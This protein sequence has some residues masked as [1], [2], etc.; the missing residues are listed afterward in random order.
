MVAT[1]SE[2][3]CQGQNIPFF[4]FSPKLDEIITAG[5][6]DNDKLF[7]MI[8]KTKT[9]MRN[10]QLSELKQ[11][12]H[13]IA[14]QQQ[15]IKADLSRSQS[16]VLPY[17][18]PVLPKRPLAKHSSVPPSHE[19]SKQVHTTNKPADKQVNGDTH[20]SSPTMCNGGHVAGK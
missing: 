5:E 15:R 6:T 11:L 10:G 8:L 12:F 1:N 9:D 3:R 20:L 2:C 14:T 13:Q 16:V 17:H 4:R 19:P 7:S 18:S